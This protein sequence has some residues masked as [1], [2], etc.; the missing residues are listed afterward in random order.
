M[1]SARGNKVANQF[2]IE[3]GDQ[4]WFQSYNTMIAVKSESG[5]VTLDSDAWDYSVTTSKYRNM[6]LG[7]TSTDCKNKIAT[8]EYL[9]DQLN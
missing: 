4:T 7:D 1:T 9:L 8:G 5:Q 3:T 2:I 6:F